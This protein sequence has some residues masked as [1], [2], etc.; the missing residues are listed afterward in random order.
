RCLEG[1]E[2]IHAA[3]PDL[4]A[5]STQAPQAHEVSE[6]LGDFRIVRELG[7]GG[8]GI[9]YEAEQMSLGR[10]VALKVLPFAATLDSRHL[11]RFKNEALAAATLDHPHIVDVYGV[12]ADRG[13]HYYAMRLID[14][15]TLAEVITQLR[16]MLE[17][18]SGPVDSVSAVFSGATVAKATPPADGTQDYSPGPAVTGET[19]G[20]MPGAVATKRSDFKPEY[21]CSV[22]ELGRCVAEALDHAHQHGVI[23]R[24]IKPSNLML[25]ARG[26]AWVTDFGLA[27]IEASSS[28][29]LTGDLVGT[30]RYMSPEQAL[31]KRVPLDH[32]TDLYSL[33]VTLYELL[34]LAPAFS[35]NDRQE[36]LRQIAFE[37]PKAPR[38]L[39]RS[40]PADLE[41]IVLKA[42]GKNPNERYTTASELAEDLQRFLH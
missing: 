26:K 3:A 41:T 27:H 38:K 30:V 8:M 20:P 4:S 16:Q 32:R 33:G 18:G 21:Y 29:T 42:M 6:P 37:E 40:I 11:Q 23:H 24:D 7:H 13:V 2:Y 25:D 19:S 28:L 35:G 34:T 1:L 39:N 15:Q 10:R 17:T 14:G 9:V 31:A 12:G 22:A 5:A 36:L